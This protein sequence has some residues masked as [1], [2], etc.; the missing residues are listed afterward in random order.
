MNN[1]EGGNRLYIKNIEIQNFRNFNNFKMDFNEGLNVIVG[2]NNSGKTGLLKAI[3][4]ISCPELI[5]TDDFNKNNIQQNY[6]SKYKEAP[7]EITIK[8]LIEHDISEDNTE[9]ESIIKLLSFIGMDK[10]SESKATSMES[11]QYTITAC[12]KMKYSLSTKEIGRYIEEV[13]KINTFDE[14]C[15]MLKLFEKYYSWHYTNGVTEFDIDKKEAT[16]IFKVDFIEAE[17]NSG[18]VYKE[19]KGEIDK[20]LKA[21]ENMVTMQKFQ[22][23]ISSEMKK[24]IEQVLVNIQSLID[25]EKNAIGLEKGYVAIA[26]DVRSTVSIS[27]S[28][29]IDVRDTK[30]GYTVPLSHNG[31]GYNNLINMYMLIR[32]TEIQ[33]GKD[34]RIL[35]LEEPESHLHPAMQYKLFKFLKN[36]DETDSLKQ[37]IFVT[38]HSSNITAVAGLDN[39]FMIDYKR[40]DGDTECVQQ[41]LQIQFKDNENSKKHMM[42]FL[43]V[44]RSDMLFADKV[45]LVEGIAEKLLLP[46]FMDKLR[47]SYEDEH[48]SIV[49]IGGKHFSHFINVFAHNAVQKKVLCVTDKDFKWFKSDV[50]EPISNYTTFVPSHIEVLNKCFNDATNVHI[51]SQQQLGQTFEDE[52]FMSNIENDYVLTRLLQIALPKTLKDFIDENGTNFYKWWNN[53]ERINKNSRDKIAPILKKY[54]CAC[55]S[56]IKD[57]NTYKKLFFAELFLTYAKDK[58]GDVALSLLVEE[59]LMNKVIV[60]DYIKEGIKWLS[61]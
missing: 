35:C 7:P 25:C 26:Q 59:N 28:Y 4:L 17:R 49:E 22:Q 18:S 50:I 20:F 8:Y 48:I 47:Y 57:A 31:L 15:D 33:K 23:D 10:I 41:S 55:K 36:L 39:M 5:C 21:D 27:D 2:A 51:V 19:T 32:L 13:K 52:L 1:K 3:H 44:T 61:K 45:I 58:K 9:D 43:D 40:Q 46:K 54:I 24:L 12:V 34:F 37:Q 14:Y 16:N 42:K 11:L 56:Y 38:T 60:P 29:V 6:S 53:L 30:S